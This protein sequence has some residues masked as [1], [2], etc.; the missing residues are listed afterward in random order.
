MEM[1]E[2]FIKINAETAKMEKRFLTISS[3]PLK[4][5]NILELMMTLCL[6]LNKC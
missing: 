2:T 6:E 1:G 5:N 4:Q 3:Y